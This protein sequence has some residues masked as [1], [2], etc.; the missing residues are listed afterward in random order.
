MLFL[1]VT[2]LPDWG[3]SD[4]AKMLAKGLLFLAKHAMKFATS[5]AIIIVF[6]FVVVF[7]DRF[8]KVLGLDYKTTFRCKLRDLCPGGS[9]SRAIELVI[10]KVEDLKAASVFSPNNVFVETH[11]GYNQPMTTRVHNNAGSSCILKERIQLNFD[12]E[13]D[14]ETLY[15]F[16]KNQKV[17]GTSE[18]CHIEFST[19]E[20]LDLEKESKE[21][22]RGG[23]D[24]TDGSFIDRTMI[25]RGRLFFRIEPITDEDYAAT[26][27]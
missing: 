1:I 10:Y 20:L 15:L 17:V 11:F 8:A 3:Y 24:W 7:K 27:C 25:P 14:E 4:Y 6:V 19:E 12:P 13:E 22:K 5:L 16:V 2:W 18:L 9:P 23:G 26:S 21:K